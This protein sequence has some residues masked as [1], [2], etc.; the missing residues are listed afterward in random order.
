MVN[1][2][3]GGLCLVGGIV[4]MLLVGLIWRKY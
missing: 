2:Q 1:L 4:L 3:W